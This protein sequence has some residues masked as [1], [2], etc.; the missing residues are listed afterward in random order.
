M[1][2]RIKTIEETKALVQ[3]YEELDGDAGIVDSCDYFL[4][5]I[6]EYN[7]HVVDQICT[8][9]K[10]RIEEAILALRP[11]DPEIEIFPISEKHPITK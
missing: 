1:N 9:I 3:K 6:D 2:E 11:T 4:R 10:E 5:H 8:S 7:D